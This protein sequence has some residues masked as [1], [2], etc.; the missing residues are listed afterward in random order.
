VN[1]DGAVTKNPPKAACGGIFRSS[2]GFTRG[3]FAQNLST[4]SAFIAEIYGAILAIEITHSKN[5]NHIWLETDSMLLMLAF[6]NN[7]MVPWSIRNR[8][9]NCMKVTRNMNFLVSHIYRE[10][11][12]C[13]DALANI[14]LNIQGFVWWQDAP[15]NIRQDVVKNKLG[16]PNFRF[17]TF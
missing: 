13:A 5:W 8:W 6:K 16:M 3:C 15:N 11:N 17:T 10:D 4:E 12:V 14:G 1:T 9:S 2:E 7:H